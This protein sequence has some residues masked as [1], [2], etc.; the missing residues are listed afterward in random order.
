M[1]SKRRL[2]LVNLLKTFHFADNLWVILAPFIMI[3]I[4]F[5]T[6]TLNAWVSK[7]FQSAKM[8]NGLGKK[9]GELVIIVI[10]E[11]LTVALSLPHYI[12]TG[13]SIYIIL[14]E[15]MSVF[16]NLAKLG[17][18]IPAFIKSAVNNVAK[19]ATEDD[20][21]TLNNKIDALHRRQDQLTREVEDGA[22]ES[23]EHQ[24]DL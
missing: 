10:G 13:I 7:T 23:E 22:T 21:V 20:L 24:E 18:P 14:M 11:V 12:I 15:L 1:A 4:D 8:R 17:V 9:V 3:V 5:L 16:E 19:S 6:G 2:K